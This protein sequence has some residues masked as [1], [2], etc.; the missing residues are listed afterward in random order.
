MKSHLYFYGSV[1]IGL[2]IGAPVFLRAVGE[3]Y[4]QLGR[5]GQI[6][7][8][9]AYGIAALF[10]AACCAAEVDDLLTDSKPR[11]DR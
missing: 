10:G 5:T 8:L 3:H 9:A 7:C 2:C 6:L 11:D 4:E 1:F